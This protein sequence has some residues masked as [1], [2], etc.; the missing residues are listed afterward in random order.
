MARQCRGERLVLQTSPMIAQKSRSFDVLKICSY[1]MHGFNN[2]R[3][4]LESLCDTHDIILLQEHW[5]S[6][7]D[8]YKLDS[9]NDK[10]NCHGVSAMD[11]KLS[12]GI[13]VG[14]PFGGVAILWKNELSN[15][16]TIVE[17]D[18]DRYVAVQFCVD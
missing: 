9:V 17:S 18:C 4:L 6:S 13:L 14:R 15:F 8:L 2:G 5:L 7:N 11:E 16:I 1:N 12:S 3:P 10:F